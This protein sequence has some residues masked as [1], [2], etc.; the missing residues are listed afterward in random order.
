MGMRTWALALSLGLTVL[1]TGT[2][3]AADQRSIYDTMPR[4][5]PGN[6]PSLGYEATSTAEFGDRI[7]F[8]EGDR[9]LNAVTVLMSSWGC[10]SGSWYGHDCATAKNATFTHSITLN[11]YAVGAGA[12]PGVRLASVTQTFK[13][14]YRPS[15]DPA[16]CTDGRWYDASAKR[17]F[18]GKAFTIS[19]KLAKQHVVVP[20][21]VI[22]T[23]AYNTS[24]Y[25]AHPIGA[26]ACGST[27]AGCP[28]D[29][30]NVGL[31]DP[32]SAL[33]AG[34]DPAPN[35]AYLSSTWGGAYCDNGAAG[36]GT[37]RLDAGCWAGY[38]PALRVSTGGGDEGDS[39]N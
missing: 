12:A 39:D 24:H 27:A 14:P 35:D 17:C 8:A 7:R 1:L 36:T 22:V 37:L 38:K 23:I 33:R 34:V 21:E 9:Q 16:N 4:P 2:A 19:F 28:Y 6:V 11:V 20:G 13:M 32:A 30:L 18:N 5:L 10:Q 26:S 15:A 25:G 29:S 31:V 3:A